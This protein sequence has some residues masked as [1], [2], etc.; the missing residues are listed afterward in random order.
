MSFNYLELLVKTKMQNKFLQTIL[1]KTFCVLLEFYQIL[2]STQE[3]QRGYL[4]ISN[5]DIYELPNDLTILAGKDCSIHYK[6]G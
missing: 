4:V 5:N 3:K 2:L 6:N 1:V